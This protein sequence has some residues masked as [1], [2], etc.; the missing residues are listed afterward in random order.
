MRIYDIPLRELCDNHLL[1]EHRELHAIYSVIAN[2]KKGYSK[3]PETLRWR[4]KLPALCARHGEQM[5]E[6]SR[7]GWVHRSPL[8]DTDMTGHQTVQ[9][10]LINT[11][12]EQRKLLAGK[13]CQCPKR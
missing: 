13:P 12:D 1:G 4:N 10:E 6:M 8:A 5:L 9:D 7:R 11:I 3:H 2:N